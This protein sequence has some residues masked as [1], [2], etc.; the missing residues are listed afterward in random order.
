[1]ML[2]PQG[3]RGR[4]ARGVCWAWRKGFCARG[5]DCIYRHEETPSTRSDNR[6]CRWEYA[7]RCH[8][9]GSCGQK[10]LQLTVAGVATRLEYFRSFGRVGKD[11][12]HRDLGELLRVAIGLFVDGD[13]ELRFLVVSTLS[14]GW[15]LEQVKLCLQPNF[16]FQPYPPQVSWQDHVVPLLRIMSDPVNTI[17]EPSMNCLRG[18]YQVV[19]DLRRR[20]FWLR[21]MKFI[22]DSLKLYPFRVAS[23]ITGV[24]TILLLAIKFDEQNLKNPIVRESVPLLVKYLRTL[25]GIYQHGYLSPVLSEAV[26]ALKH[27]VSGRLSVVDALT[28]VTSK[29][30]PDDRATN[31]KVPACGG[32]QG[33][34]RVAGLSDKQQ[35]TGMPVESLEKRLLTFATQKLVTGYLQGLSGHTVNGGLIAGTGFFDDD[36]DIENQAQTG[37]EGLEEELENIPYSYSHH[38]DV[39]IGANQAGLFSIGPQKNMAK[40]MVFTNGS[41]DALFQRWKERAADPTKLN[42]DWG[43]VSNTNSMKDF[44]QVTLTLFVAASTETRLQFISE[45]LLKDEYL[46]KLWEC[47]N[48]KLPTDSINHPSPKYSDHVSTI[49]HIM[50]HPDVVNRREFQAVRKELSGM[51][52]SIPNYLYGILEYMKLH[53]RSKAKNTEMIEACVKSIVFILEGVFRLIDPR[54]IPMEF[55][56]EAKEFMKFAISVE[57]AIPWEKRTDSLTTEAVQSFMRADE[58][59]FPISKPPAIC[60]GRREDRIRDR[61]HVASGAKEG[62]PSL[63]QVS[64]GISDRIKSGNIVRPVQT[65]LDQDAEEFKKNARRERERR[66]RR[67]KEDEEGWDDGKPIIHRA[68]YSPQKKEEPVQ[69]TMQEVEEEVQPMND[70]E[71]LAY[72]EK[73]KLAANADIENGGPGTKLKN[74]FIDAH[75]PLEERAI[76]TVSQTNKSRIFRVQPAMER[77][78]DEEPFRGDGGSSLNEGKSASVKTCSRFPKQSPHGAIGGSIYH[79]DSGSS[80]SSPKGESVLRYVSRNVPAAPRSEAILERLSKDPK[81]AYS[82]VKEPEIWQSGYN[83]C[84]D[85][86]AASMCID[87]QD[88]QLTPGHEIKTE[89]ASGVG[90]TRPW[91][92]SDRPSLSRAWEW[93]RLEELSA[94]PAENGVR[95]GP[96]PRDKA[97]ADYYRA[98]YGTGYPKLDLDK[99]VHIGDELLE[100]AGGPQGQDQGSDQNDLDDRVYTQ[101]PQTSPR[102]LSSSKFQTYPSKAL[103]QDSDQSIGQSRPQT[104]TSQ[105]ESLCLGQAPPIEQGMPSGLPPLKEGEPRFGTAQATE[106]LGVKLTSLKLGSLRRA[107]IEQPEPN[108]VTGSGRLEVIK[109]PAA[110]HKTQDKASKGG[111]NDASGS[112][113]TSRHLVPLP[114]RPLATSSKDPVIWPDARLEAAEAERGRPIARLTNRHDQNLLPRRLSE[115]RNPDQAKEYLPCGHTRGLNRNEEYCNERVNKKTPY[116]GHDANVECSN[117]MKRWQCKIVCGAHLPCSHYC[118]KECFQCLQEIKIDGTPIWNHRPCQICMKIRAAQER[119]KNPEGKKGQAGAA[120]I[121]GRM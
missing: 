60:S 76:M 93:W 57:N 102:G 66:N 38:G 4:A 46:G 64:K 99:S 100:C 98:I 90:E 24:I 78:L 43:K 117:S 16:L 62:N 20:H 21:V 33:E 22:E 29:T 17:H 13:Q 23:Q 106:E 80:G 73:I 26:D 35:D 12:T 27:T 19:F 88:A 69:E 53:S 74:T 77:I 6:V 113:I 28:A 87:E 59:L 63:A 85:G 7:T 3:G 47:L 109:L 105:R 120:N 84:A 96:R 11:L 68:E 55:R 9:H 92:L 65:Y 71:A 40:P 54:N 81:M 50:S 32:V 8:S 101:I 2:P 67:R 61:A 111:E 89:T 70:E 121:V 86:L 82:S 39:S 41:G 83:Q 91:V 42:F 79:D 116:C 103:Q 94:R 34:P 58:K 5:P 75:R 104:Q 48:V 114:P 118:N 49:V 10:H 30:R 108:T 51:F 36:D 37:S 115:I 44:L 112:Q 95:F 52:A 110:G 1:M 18:L 31:L 107:E 45:Y 56:Y 119:R 72:L 15:H 97:T 14:S 25:Q